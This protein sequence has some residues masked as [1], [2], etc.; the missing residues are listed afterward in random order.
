[1]KSGHKT[2]KATYQHWLDKV[3]TDK[4]FGLPA[5]ALIMWIVF[6]AT[7]TL[8]AYPQQ[9]IEQGVAALGKVVESA[10]TDG[11]LKDLIVDGI[12][13]GVGGVLVF[14]PNILIL[15]FF[16]ALLE[17][18]GFMSRAAK[19]VDKIMHRI[20]LHG[21]SFIPYII[22]FGCNVP[23][24]MAT[25][26]LHTSR[27]RIITILTIPF[28][29]C[30]ARLPVYMLFVSAFFA[31]NQGL[32]LMSVYCAGIVMAALTSIL[33]SKTLLKK[34]KEDHDT[35]LPPIQIPTARNALRLMWDK[36]Y[37]Y[38]KKIGTV[39]LFASILIWA[40]GYFPR[41]EGQTQQEQIENSFMGRLGKSVEPAVKP[42]G[43]N[44]QMGITLF[45]G[46]AAKEIMVS[47]MGVLYTGEAGNTASLKQKLQT[48]KYDDGTQVFTPI[49]AYSFMLFAL[50]YFPCIATLSA[51]RREI[52]SRWMLLSLT[53]ST[54]V[55]WL[56]SFI[57]YQTATYIQAL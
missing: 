17:E 19:L 8:G 47:T 49:I 7:F 43:F 50:L 20:G 21:E 6:Q 45:T 36:G 38:L 46:A 39:V 32:I 55:A 53:Y 48:A 24:I 23:A 11:M 27:D 12:I 22:G 40:L 18:S 26:T 29:S 14:L 15:F 10:M 4:W 30:S 13:A 1:M 31:V 3:M 9:W 57:F 54:T 42:L 56:V 16:I 41:H 51:I 52:G 34:D 37:Q 35:E 44:W 2:N 28:M 5:L 25:D 33:L